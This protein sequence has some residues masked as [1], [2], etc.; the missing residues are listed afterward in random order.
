MKGVYSQPDNILGRS[1][2]QASSLR[3]CHSLVYPLPFHLCRKFECCLSYFLLYFNFA[4]IFDSLTDFLLL[5]LR[6]TL[7]NLTITIIVRYYY[8]ALFFK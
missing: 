1:A 6:I 2:Q 5:S 3:K 4:L 7:I 8:H